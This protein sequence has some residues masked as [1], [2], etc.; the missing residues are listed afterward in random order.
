MKNLIKLCSALF[1]ITL[2]LSCDDASEG[3]IGNDK[4]IIQP[5]GYG[6]GVYYFPCHER[7]FAT[8]LANFLSDTSKQVL[9]I[10]GDGTGGY[11]Y[12]IGYFVV[13]KQ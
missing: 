1:I 6:N 3:P 12:D 11:G 8:S 5:I 9:A 4:A 13:V 10:T 7:T 2:L